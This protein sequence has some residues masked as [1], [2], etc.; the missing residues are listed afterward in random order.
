MK[1][2]KE[3]FH[4]IYFTLFFSVVAGFAFFIIKM[5]VKTKTEI[6]P[7]EFRAAITGIKFQHGSSFL[8]S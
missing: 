8:V 2:A 5:V 7:T 4:F 1:T 6:L 3:K